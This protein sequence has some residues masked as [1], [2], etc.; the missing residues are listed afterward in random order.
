MLDMQSANEDCEEEFHDAAYE[1][2][3]ICPV[4]IYS[5]STQMFFILNHF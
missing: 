1:L 2:E 4:V 5:P 3:D